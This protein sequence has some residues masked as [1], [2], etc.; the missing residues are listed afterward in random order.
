M[1]TLLTSYK[2]LPCTHMCR[3]WFECPCGIV[4]ISTHVYTFLLVLRCPHSP[5]GSDLFSKTLVLTC[6]HTQLGLIWIPTHRWHDLHT[7]HYRSW[8]VHAAYK[9]LTCTHMYRSWF[10]C[11]RGIV[12]ISTHILRSWVEW[13][14][15][16]YCL[17]FHTHA[18]WVCLLLSPHL[19]CKSPTPFLGI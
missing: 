4:Y 11:P 14:P 17:H 18:M 10:E 5:I 12:Y 16:W 3:S 8:Y 7:H 13:M 19:W 9:V 6:T 2:V 1:Y 15:T